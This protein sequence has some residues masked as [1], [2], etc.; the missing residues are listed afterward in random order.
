MWYGGAA[1]QGR[2]AA[3]FSLDNL[4]LEGDAV[5]KDQVKA[6]QLG[7]YISA[8]I[9]RRAAAAFGGGSGSGGGENPYS[10]YSGPAAAVCNQGDKSAI[11]RYREHQETQEDKRKDGVQ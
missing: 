4:C 10:S 9:D 5:L 6:V 11:D 7:K 2:R 3:Q 1:A 8:Q